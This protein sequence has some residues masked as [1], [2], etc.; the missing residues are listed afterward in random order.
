MFSC[1]KRIL[2][3]T[4]L[5]CAC[6]S[7]PPLT[8]ADRQALARE[9]RAT[10]AELTE[11]I[12]DH[13][14]ERVAAFY[15][16]ASEFLFLGCTS[17]LTGGARFKQVV[18]P[19]YGPTR[20]ATF[21]QRVATVQV[22]SP[23]AAVALQYGSSNRASGLFWTRVLVKEGARWVI[24][25]EHQSWPDCAPPPAPHPQTTPSDSARLRPRGSVR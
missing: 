10:L 15:T 9:V 2:P 17:A 22:L 6:V 12:N 8:E 18:V 11:A 21:E 13:E 23:T 4:L 14:T 16:D 24:T 5:V 25:Y 1:A 20:G 19:T 3:V 7:S